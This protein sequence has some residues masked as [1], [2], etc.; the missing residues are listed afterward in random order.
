MAAKVLEYMKQ[1]GGAKL[2]G[3][4]NNGCL[5]TFAGAAHELA[6]F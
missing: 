1:N 3:W 2:N 6:L 5:C 4:L